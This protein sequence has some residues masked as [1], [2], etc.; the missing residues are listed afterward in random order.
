MLTGK[1]T[2]LNRR[3]PLQEQIAILE[4]QIGLIHENLYRISFG[5]GVDGNLGEN[6]DGIWQVF[7][8]SGTPDAEN[9]VPHGLGIIPRA[10]IN[11]G[12][13][14]AG[15]LYQLLTTGTNWDTTNIY[16]KC[17]VASVEFRIFILK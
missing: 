3:L 13:D 12:Q 10:L 14:K 17:D 11:C 15:S 7:T 16:L 4:Q 1:G 9:T 2:L 5:N 8:T 6:V